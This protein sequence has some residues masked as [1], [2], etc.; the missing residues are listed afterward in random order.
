MIDNKCIDQ[1]WSWRTRSDKQQINLVQWFL[2]LLFWK[3]KIVTDL[4]HVFSDQIN[5]SVFTCQDNKE[6]NTR[7]GMFWIIIDYYWSDYYWILTCGVAHWRGSVFRCCPLLH[8]QRSAAVSVRPVGV[9]L[10]PAQRR[11]R[12]REWRWRWWWG[13]WWW[14]GGWDKESPADLMGNKK[15]LR[16]QMEVKVWLYVI[17]V[18]VTSHLPCDARDW[19]SLWEEGPDRRPGLMGSGFVVSD[20][21]S[22]PGLLWREKPFY[23]SGPVEFSWWVWSRPGLMGSGSLKS[24]SL[25]SSGPGHRLWS[26]VCLDRN[27]NSEIAI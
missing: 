18:S 5:I 16:G 27:K 1:W 26:N 11:R 10:F 7:D 6:R 2:I 20:L 9:A 24:T 17:M 3:N 12:R 25:S 4:F 13:W 22:D 14:W 21:V 19:P 15:A 23:L 8:R